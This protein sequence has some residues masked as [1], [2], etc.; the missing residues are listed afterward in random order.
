M[1]AL[2]GQEIP[3]EISLLENAI[4]AEGA[5]HPSKYSTCHYLM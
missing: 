3:D 4:T 5:M 2:I 1:G